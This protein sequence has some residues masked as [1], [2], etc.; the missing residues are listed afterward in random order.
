M[1]VYHIFM[2]QSFIFRGKAPGFKPGAYSVFV[3]Y[4]RHLDDKIFSVS[5]TG[6]GR[7]VK[8]LP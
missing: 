2:F 1:T 5:H 7:S 8:L 3:H 4:V 6:A